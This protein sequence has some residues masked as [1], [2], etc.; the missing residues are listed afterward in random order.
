MKNK[1][2]RWFYILANFENGKELQII[3]PLK[4]DDYIVSSMVDDTIFEVKIH[5]K[6]YRITKSFDTEIDATKDLLLR[7]KRFYHYHSIKK[8]KPVLYYDRWDTKAQ[9]TVR[10]L[11]HKFREEYPEM[12]I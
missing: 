10:S 4:A 2:Q 5:K 7:I 8:N 3:E 6:I 12:F 9:E 1:T 11:R